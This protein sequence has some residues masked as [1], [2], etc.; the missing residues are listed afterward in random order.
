[1]GVAV[2]KNAAAGART[3]AAL[4]DSRCYCK[5]EATCGF[6]LASKV[7]SKPP[8][9]QM[10]VT[11]VFTRRSSRLRAD[12]AVVLWR[13]LPKQLRFR[14]L[15]VFLILRTSCRQPQRPEP[16]LSWAL[17]ALHWCCSPDS[18]LRVAPGSGEVTRTWAGTFEPASPWA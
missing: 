2:R 1:M 9:G 12:S 8:L 4:L 18:L 7:R 13:P 11:L 14:D 10:T 5:P 16:A 6:P 3:P 17:S 15:S